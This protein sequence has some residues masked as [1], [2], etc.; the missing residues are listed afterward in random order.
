MSGITL[1]S[2]QGVRLNTAADDRNA[3]LTIRG[4]TVSYGQ[5]PAVYSIDFTA[6]TG[7]LMGIVGPNG[8][9][10]STLLKAAM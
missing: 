3:P 8:A 5:V 9:G 1:V 10:K 4:L 6:P 7:S 2:D